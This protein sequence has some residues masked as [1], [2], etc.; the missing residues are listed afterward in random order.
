MAADLDELA[1]IIAALPRKQQLD[2]VVAILGR[3]AL[4]ID[5]LP[6]PARGPEAFSASLSLP[7]RDR[8]LEGLD[9]LT[10][11][12]AALVAA[13]ALVLETSEPGVQFDTTTLNNFIGNARSTP[14][15]IQSLN[16]L[17][18]DHYLHAVPSTRATKSFRFTPL[19]LEKAKLVARG[20]WEDAAQL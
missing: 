12:D 13:L 1:G 10:G 11:P 6:Q 7:P 16:P 15:N 5:S 14:L 8:L 20:L 3:I 9:S 4:S 19:G 2:L 17:C 18:V